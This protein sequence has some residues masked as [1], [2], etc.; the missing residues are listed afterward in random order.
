MRSRAGSRC[1]RVSPLTRARALRPTAH[2]FALPPR[3]CARRSTASRLCCALEIAPALPVTASPELDQAK[4]MEAVKSKRL[5][6][7]NFYA[8]WCPHCIQ[9][10]PLW[11]AAKERI[12]ADDSFADDVALIM[13]SGRRRCR[14]GNV[15]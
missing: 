14:R 3:P 5:V 4:F 13:V 12:D 7:V 8:P 11:R 1:S 2:A 9:F 10:A 15:W 6:M